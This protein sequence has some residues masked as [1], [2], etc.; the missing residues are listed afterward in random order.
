MNYMG[1]I[2]LLFDFL[3]HLTKVL[4]GVDVKKESKLLYQNFHKMG[5]LF[6]LFLT[7]VHS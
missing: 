2:F 4:E 5:E 1:H 3:A 7:L 6:Q